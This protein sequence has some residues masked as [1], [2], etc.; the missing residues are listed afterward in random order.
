MSDGA[1]GGWSRVCASAALADGGDGLRLRWRDASG[2]VQAAFVVRVSGTVRA[3]LNRCAHV[4]VE[5]D[6]MPGRFLDESG[7][8]LV[9]ATHGAMY[10][11]ADGRCAG[12]PCRGRG[13]LQPIPARERDGAVWVQGPCEPDSDVSSSTPAP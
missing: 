4:P 5:L 6:W 3:F 7:L 13:G 11:A 8:Y 1:A 10:D 9:C 2:T 12:G